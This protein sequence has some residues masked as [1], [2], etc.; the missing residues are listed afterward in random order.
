MLPVSASGTTGDPGASNGGASDLDGRQP[1]G[2]QWLVDREPVLRR[3]RGDAEH[4]LKQQERRRGRPGLRDAR[5]RVGD[6]RAA[7]VAIEAAE[8]LGKAEVARARGDVEQAAGD[9]L[10][11]RRGIRSA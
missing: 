11:R 2:E 8:E 5:D 4:R 1:V 7:L 10:G 6:G 3:V 9:P